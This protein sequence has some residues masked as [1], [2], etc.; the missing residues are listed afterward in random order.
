MKS[1]DHHL[2]MAGEQVPVEVSEVVG[3]GVLTVIGE[4]EAAAGAQATPGS[5]E[6]ALEKAA[7]YQ[8]EVLELLEE[9]GVEAGG[10]G[11]GHHQVRNGIGA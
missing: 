7:R 6:R 3:V 10:R 5:Q 4:L 1:L 8:R 11:L 9:F 2:A